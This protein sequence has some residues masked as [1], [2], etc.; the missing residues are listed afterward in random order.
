MT[1]DDLLA[2]LSRLSAHQPDALDAY[3]FGDDA[4]EM[5]P[6][7][8]VCRTLA[9][10]PSSKLWEREAN[11]LSYIG[12]RETEELSDYTAFTARL[13]AAALERGVYPIILSSLSDSGF[14]RFGLRVERIIGETAVPR[15]KLS[16]SAFGT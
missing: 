13:A 9:P 15:V 8:A 4:G 7:L 3:V 6:A 12:I 5:A 11:A 2:V 16:W 10:V 1:A 14:T